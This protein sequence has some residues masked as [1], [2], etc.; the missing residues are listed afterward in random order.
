M[1]ALKV[2]ASS[3][4][5]SLVSLRT[6]PIPRQRHSFAAPWTVRTIRAFKKVL[7]LEATTSS[8]GLLTARKHPT[9]CSNISPDDQGC[10]GRRCLF[11]QLSEVDLPC[12]HRGRTGKLCE[13]FRMPAHREGEAGTGAGVLWHSLAGQANGLIRQGRGSHPPWSGASWAGARRPLAETCGLSAPACAPG[14]QTAVPGAFL[15]NH[16]HLADRRWR[17]VA[18]ASSFHPSSYGQKHTAMPNVISSSSTVLKRSSATRASIC[19]RPR[20]MQCGRRLV[21]APARSSSSRRPAQTPRSRD[22]VPR[23]A[24]GRTIS[25][26]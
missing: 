3:P 1:M 22:R 12:L 2:S 8:F 25:S 20:P 26:S 7:P 21:A 6:L 23:R 11:R 18:F 16:H 9:R 13:G 14:E 19:T 5:A 10:P 4:S 24:P 17:R 15:G